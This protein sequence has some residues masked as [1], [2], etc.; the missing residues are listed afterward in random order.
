MSLVITGCYYNDL[1]TIFCRLQINGL[2]I[3]K[4]S[5][6]QSFT[7][8]QVNKYLVIGSVIAYPIGSVNAFCKQKIGFLMIHDQA[9]GC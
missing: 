8:H 3:K 2:I 1:G 7:R 5:W 4:C 9:L 6:L